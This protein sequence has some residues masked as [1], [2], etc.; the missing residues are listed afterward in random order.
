M[1]V[2]REIPKNKRGKK[3]T[4][5]ME[6][7][8]KVLFLAIKSQMERHLQNYIGTGHRIKPIKSKN[9]SASNGNMTNKNNKTE[10]N[11]LNLLGNFDG[12]KEKR[13]KKIV[14]FRE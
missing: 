9:H 1:S 13:N 7:K 8:N 5:K 6:T 14:L 11:Y 4:N 3:A 12:L 2:S 10:G